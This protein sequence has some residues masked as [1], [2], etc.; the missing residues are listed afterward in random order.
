MRD[1]DVRRVLLERLNNLYSDDRN[2]I[3][4][5]ELGLCGG[6]V[7]VDVAVV[8]GCLKGYEIKSDRDTLKRLGRQAITYGKVFDS[9]TLV[10]GET[11]LAQAS[12]L[13]PDWWGIE[14]AQFDRQS[15]KT[16]L[17]PFRP[18]KP[19]PGIEPIDLARLLWRDEV[20]SVLDRIVPGHKLAQKSRKHLWK[21]LVDAVPVDELKVIVRDGLRNRMRWRVVGKHT[22]YD[23]RLQPCATS[24]DCLSQPARSRS[25]R[26]NHRPN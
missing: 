4:V 5:E 20:L 8:N 17:V 6:F 22:Q 18:E 1:V 10:S 19:N 2:T 13:L 24:S 25:H 9:V 26:Y 7:R 12:A 3:I 11:H 15:G 16:Q 21:A 14:V 23:E